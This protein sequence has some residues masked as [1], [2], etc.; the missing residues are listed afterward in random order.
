M[1]IAF[2]FCSHAFIQTVCVCPRVSSKRRKIHTVC[3]APLSL[4]TPVQW[5]RAL[6]STLTL[7]VFCDFNWIRHRWTNTHTCETHIRVQTHTHSPSFFNTQITLM[8]TLSPISEDHNC[9]WNSAWSLSLLLLV[10]GGYS[11]NTDT[12]TQ[13]C[14]PFSISQSYFLQ[15]AC[16]WLWWLNG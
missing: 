14:L 15:K 12:H 5:R 11:V 1:W 7:A 10:I 2:D 8:L 13:L 16:L 4:C 6:L 9:S 3:L